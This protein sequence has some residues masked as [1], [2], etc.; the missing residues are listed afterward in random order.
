MWNYI[1]RKRK[2]T[3]N[4]IAIATGVSRPTIYLFEEG[5][6]QNIKLMAYYLRLNGREIDKQLA[7]ILD[8]DYE[9]FYAKFGDKIPPV[10]VEEL[11]TLKKN[12]AG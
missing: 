5:K 2:K 12:L 11:E 7:D 3:I 10:L 1:R 4:E 6:C 8:N 9:E